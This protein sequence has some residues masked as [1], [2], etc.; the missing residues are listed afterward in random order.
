[1]DMGNDI[2][3]KLMH[4]FFQLHRQKMNSGPVEGM[5]H[6]EMRVLRSI[7]KLDTGQGVMVSELSNLWNVS[8]P[9][10][11]QTV[12]GLVTQGLVERSVDPADRRAVR[13]RLTSKGEE[14]LHQVSQKFVASFSGLT[15]HLGLEQS[16]SLLGLLE[17]VYQYF[18]SNPSGG[19]S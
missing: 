1:M 18:E 10:A 9:S 12:N 4:V 7:F 17:Q 8:A 19:R 14:V 13:L 11:T 6:G 5:R 15:Q 16:E 3:Y 2:A